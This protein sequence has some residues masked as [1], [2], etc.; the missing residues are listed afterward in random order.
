LLVMVVHDNQTYQNSHYETL[1]WHD[2][3]EH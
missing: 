2:K 1:L 3:H